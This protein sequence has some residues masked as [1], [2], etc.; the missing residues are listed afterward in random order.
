MKKITELRT[1]T[2]NR[3]YNILHK[4]VHADCSHCTWHSCYF[5]NYHNENDSWKYYYFYER[6]Y[7]PKWYRKRINL[8]GT[9][10]YPNWKLVSKNR[11]Q[12]MKKPFIFQNKFDNYD[13]DWDP[14]VEI[15]WKL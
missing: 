14:C 13:Q 10:K 5:G 15:I 12:W 7:T 3:V 4:E 9:G 2:S 11:K 8:K 6:D 1:T